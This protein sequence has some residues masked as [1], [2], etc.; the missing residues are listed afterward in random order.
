MRL[1]KILADSGYGSRKEVKSLLKQGLVFVNGEKVLQAKLQLDPEKDEIVVNGEILT[2]K[3]EIYLMMNKAAGV[4]TATRDNSQATVLDDIDPI[5]RRKELY[6][7]GRLDKDTTGLLL[8]TTDGQLGHRLL[9]PKWHVEK[10]YQALVKGPLPTDACQ[11]FASGMTIDGGEI[12]RP[13][14]LVLTEKAETV[15]Y[16]VVYISLTEGKFHQV[17]RMVK[18]LGSEVLALKR[19]SMGSLKLDPQLKA[20]E[21]RELTQKELRDL[22]NNMV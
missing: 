11:R 17:K 2:Y 4:L 14:R 3:K 21:Y 1:D 6:P 10:E 7:V 16:Q 22:S 9:S 12:C 19:V 20:G 8:L 18:A 15:P 13:A 5:Y